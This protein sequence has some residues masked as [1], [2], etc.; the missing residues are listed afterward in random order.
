MYP[1]RLILDDARN[2]GISVLSLDVNHSDKVYRVERV[3]PGTGSGGWVPPAI[4]WSEPERDGRDGAFTD[5][6]Q[7]G[8]RGDPA[9]KATPAPVGG[10]PALMDG[11][12]AVVQVDVAA[13][14]RGADLPAQDEEPTAEEENKGWRLRTKT[15]SWARVWL[16][17]GP[18]A[19]EERAPHG[20]ETR[21]C[22][23]A[24]VRHST[25][26]VRGEGHQR[27]RGGEDGREPSLSLVGR[28]LAPCPGFPADRGTA[29]PGRRVRLDLRADRSV[30]GPGPG[31]YH[32]A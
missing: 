13:P 18:R 1:K 20:R 11:V 32:P 25:V 12:S 10:E 6:A 8:G 5:L 3:D 17:S 28:F 23:T 27:S 22:P 24:P 16:R 31:S 30:A 19:G 14:D 29:G 21:I 9:I 7:T 4:G 2:F 26:P 15:R